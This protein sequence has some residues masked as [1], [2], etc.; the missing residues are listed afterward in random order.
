M[1]LKLC[2]E[3]IFPLTPREWIT[4]QGPGGGGWGCVAEAPTPSSS[5]IQT[6]SLL[7]ELTSPSWLIKFLAPK[8]GRWLCI[9]FLILHS[10]SSER[11]TAHRLQRAEKDYTHLCYIF[12]RQNDTKR[13]RKLNHPDSH[14]MT[15][16][17]LSCLSELF[18]QHCGLT[19]SHID[20]KRTADRALTY[21]PEFKPLWV[22]WDLIMYI[23]KSQNQWLLN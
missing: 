21:S 15:V 18:W 11:Q 3:R 4:K 5:L 23:K 8:A 2:L 17:P 10:N 19:W 12:T 22:R 1:K 14:L 7:S 13:N 16:T 6:S 20:E 9:Y